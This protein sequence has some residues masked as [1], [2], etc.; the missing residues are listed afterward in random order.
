MSACSFCGAFTS[1]PKRVQDDLVCL[2]CVETADFDEYE[3][4]LKRALAR[5]EAKRRFRSTL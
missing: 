3:A 5:Y 4:A 2:D 1:E